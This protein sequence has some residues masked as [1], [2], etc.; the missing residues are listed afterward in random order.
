MSTL[1]QR[2]TYLS[3]NLKEKGIK[4]IEVNAK[5]S[6]KILGIYSKKDFDMQKNMMGLDLE[7]DINTSILYRDEL[8]SISCAMTGYLHLISQTDTVGDLDGMGVIPKI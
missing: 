7:G 4:H 2:G 5:A 3:K 8:D 6:A 1:A